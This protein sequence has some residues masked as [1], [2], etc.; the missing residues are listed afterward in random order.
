[1]WCDVLSNSAVED[2]EQVI[3]GGSAFESIGGLTSELLVSLV[4]QPFRPLW[5]PGCQQFL[6]VDR[7]RGTVCFGRLD[8]NRLS[9]GHF[10]V[11]AHHRLVHTADLLYIQRPVAEPL[12]IEDKQVVQHSKDNPIGNAREVERVLLTPSCTVGPPFQEG[13]S[14]GIKQIA[15]T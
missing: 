4:S 11:K 1:M 5:R 12:A 8:G 7:R 10:Q 14:V 3:N 13:I 6:Q 2:R 15:L 9:L